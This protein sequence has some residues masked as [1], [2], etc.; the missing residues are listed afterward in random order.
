MPVTEVPLD[1]NLTTVDVFAELSD[2]VHQKGNNTD[3]TNAVNHPYPVMLTWGQT[4]DTP[5][6]DSESPNA[7]RLSCVRANVTMPGSVKVSAGAS[8]IGI[9][10]VTLATVAAL[11]VIF[12]GI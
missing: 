7:A 10:T 9:P 2:Y 12:L 6:V 1:I 5:G 11:W 8:V 4:N 3:Y